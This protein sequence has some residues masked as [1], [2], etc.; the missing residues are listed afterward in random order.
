MSREDS[1]PES[2]TPNA[3]ATSPD[4]SCARVQLSRFDNSWYQPGRGVAVRVLWIVANAMVMQNPLFLSS[5]LKCALLR[6][7]GARVGRGVNIKPNVNVKY[8]WRLQIGDDAWIGEGAWLDSLA[9]ISIGANACVS[10]GAYFC[11]GNHDWSDPAFGL[12]VKPIIV[13]DGAWIGARA[14]L[15]PGVTVGSHA[16]VAAGAVM[17][18]NADAWTIYS[19]NPARAVK[20]RV[21]R[22]PSG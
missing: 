17:S 7:F 21:L 16:V 8:P 12:V 18:K 2:A 1:P 19:G 9:Q 20:K 13:E 5:T 11:T 3:A 4:T 22:M 15:L 10:Q 6:A 14:V